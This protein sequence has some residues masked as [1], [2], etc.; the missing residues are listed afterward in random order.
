MVKLKILVVLNDLDIGGAQNYTISLMNEFLKLGNE[1][2]LRI[3]SQNVPLLERLN[4]NINVKIYS[5]NSKLDFRIIKKIRNELKYENYDAVISSDIHYQKIANYFINKDYKIL[6][7]IHFTIARGSKS[8]FINFITFR[9]KKK[10]EI[11]ITSIE[12][13][14]NYL[15]KKYKLNKSFFTQIHNGVDTNKFILA[16][17]SFSRNEFL[18]RIGIDPISKVILM[19]AGFREEKRHIDAVKAFSKLFNKRKDVYLVLVGDN[20][21][22]EQNLLQ[23]FVDINYIDN[24]KIFSAAE[25]GNIIDYYWAADLFTLT[26]DKVETFPIS[27]LEAMSCGVPCVL[28]DVGGA[29]DIIVNDTYGRVV[30]KHDLDAIS[31]SWIDILESKID[32]RKNRAHIEQNYSLTIAVEKYLNLMRHSD[33]N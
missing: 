2:H 3:L 21:I 33:V 1:V 29:K 9:F 23:E 16:P 4:K 22:S 26:S 18:L 8:Y 19:V 5:R 31:K 25:A 28:T 10:N 6:Y 12:R 14:T 7:P 11:F 30:P 15:V 17:K 32:A 13:Q 20:R 24:V 27:V